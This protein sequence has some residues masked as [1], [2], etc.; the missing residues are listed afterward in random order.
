MSMTFPNE[1]RDYRIGRDVLLTSE[2][3]L[4]RQMEAVAAALRALPPGGEVSEDYLFERAGAGA[5]RDDAAGLVR[6]SELFGG[7]DTLM[8]YH[9]MFP[10]HSQDDRPGPSAGETPLAEGGN[11][12][13][14]ARAPAERVAAFA[15][16]KGWKHARLLSAAGEQLPARLWRR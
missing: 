6:M 7:G 15:R 10:R 4:R 5:G 13:I 14:V 2:I 11:L 3:A 9:Y 16:D 8:I 1:T 12:W